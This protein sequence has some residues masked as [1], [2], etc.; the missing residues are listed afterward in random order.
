MGVVCEGSG[1]SCPSTAARRIK[2]HTFPLFFGILAAVEAVFS[3][4]GGLQVGMGGLEE[5][6]RKFLC[7]G[8]TRCLHHSPLAFAWDSDTVTVGFAC[9]PALDIAR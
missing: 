8:G 1:E 7:S 5:D 3:F 9:L 6:G 4:C 2:Q